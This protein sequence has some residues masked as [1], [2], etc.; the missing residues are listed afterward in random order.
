MI[1]GAASKVPSDIGSQPHPPSMSD[2]GGV[3][4]GTEHKA[5]LIEAEVEAAY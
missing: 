2:P 5:L 3:G 4:F 1:I